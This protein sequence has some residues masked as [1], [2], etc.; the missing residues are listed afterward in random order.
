MVKVPL[1]KVNEEIRDELRMMKARRKDK[2][3]SETLEYLIGL[4]ARIKELEESPL[5]SLTH[6]EIQAI[7]DSTNDVDLWDP[8]D[9]EFTECIRSA[10][11]KLHK[12]LRLENG[13]LNNE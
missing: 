8:E 13:G 10:N 9:D 6:N 5:L 12:A 11:I 7:Y 3:L 2:G 4:E 1:P